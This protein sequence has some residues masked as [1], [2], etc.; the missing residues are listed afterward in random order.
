MKDNRDLTAGWRIWVMF[1]AT[2]TTMARLRGYCT[3]LMASLRRKSVEP[4][5]AHQA[6]SATIGL[7]CKKSGSKA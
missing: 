6:P 3:G 2:P 1:W 5:V 7:R 4:M